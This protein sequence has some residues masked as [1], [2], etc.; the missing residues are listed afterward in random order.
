[1][2][3]SVAQTVHLLD[4]KKVV[5]IDPTHA[6]EGIFVYQVTKFGV[7][8]PKKGKA[9]PE[10]IYRARA[11]NGQEGV[12]TQTIQ[13][14]KSEAGKYKQYWDPEKDGAKPV[15]PTKKKRERKTAADKDA[16]LV[17]TIVAALAADK[18][19]KKKAATA[20]DAPKK[21]RKTA[22]EK[23]EELMQR[24]KA[25]IAAQQK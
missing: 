22:E 10:H 6:E 2:S 8:L 5:V 17:E 23:Q 21:K 11:V 4:G 3:R 1:M 25:L 12:A 13:L 24:V 14:T 9:G 16:A 19:L 7:P 20:T 15:D 18:P